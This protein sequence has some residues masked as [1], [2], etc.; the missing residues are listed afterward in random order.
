MYVSGTWFSII[1]IRS[2]TFFLYFYLRQL[3]IIFRA[4]SRQFPRKNVLW[5]Q[6]EPTNI[7]HYKRKKCFSGESLLNG[8]HQAHAIDKQLYGSH[9]A[10]A[11]GLYLSAWE[12][13]NN[14]TWIVSSS[15]QHIINVN[16]FKANR[17]INSRAREI[18]NIRRHQRHPRP[19]FT[20]S[21]HSSPRVNM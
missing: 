7:R 8:R 15:H 4:K 5:R 11:S 19:P 2:D 16:W 18:S 12:G 14:W 6:V 21:G 20:W 9:I 13:V 1:I 3:T 10:T 17:S